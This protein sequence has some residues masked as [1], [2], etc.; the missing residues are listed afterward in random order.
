MKKKVLF[1]NNTMGRAGAERTLLALLEMFDKEKYDVHFLAIIPRGEF[2]SLFPDGVKILNKKYSSKVIMDKKSLVWYILFVLRALFNKFNFIR[3][4]PYMIK[5]LFGQIKQKNFSFDKLFW[6]VLAYNAPVLKDEYDLA[7]AYIEGASLYYV[8]DRVK[9][10]KKVSF[11]HIDYM[12]SGY[13]AK[14]DKPY[15][16]KADK[17]YGVSQSVVESIMST[18]PECK[19]KTE[20]FQN[21]ISDRFVIESSNNGEGFK[22]DFDGI[23]LLTI[24]R[25]HYQKAYDIAIKA[26]AS[27]LEK[28]DIKIRWYI[29]GEGIERGNLEKQ[30]AKYQLKDKFILL[31]GKSNPYPY[32]KQ[33]DIYVH[34]TRYE[35][36]CIATAEAR[37]LCKPIIASDTAGIKEQLSNENAVIIN[38]N[39]QEIISSILKLAKN[40]KLRRDMSEKFKV[41]WERPNDIYKLEELI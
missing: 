20:M 3:F 27:I 24:G 33:C 22:D 30:I 32:L 18:F 7:I 8:T 15:F 13:V 11:V 34:A 25:L 6:K 9:A 4:L 38:L 10:K 19:Y 40:E 17:I 39:E 23:R 21:T 28:T 41:K 14:L 37:I 2:F 16:D 35:G 12:R 26:F 5:N 1:V 29:I 31:G 36:W